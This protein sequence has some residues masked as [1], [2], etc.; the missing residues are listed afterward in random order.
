MLPPG[1]VL[2]G[3]G[4]DAPVA[5]SNT[6][7]LDSLACSVLGQVQ[8]AADFG[9]RIAHSIGARAHRVRLVWQEQDEITGKW[10]EV[11]SLELVPV[12]ITEGR[13]NLDD[14]APGQVPVGQISL[15][16]VSSIQVDEATLRGYLNGEQWTTVP[17]REFFYEVQQ[18]PRCPTDPEPER[19]RYVLAAVPEYKADDLEWRVRLV[20]QFGRRERDGSDA[21][22]PGEFYPPIDGATLMS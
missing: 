9:R 10:S 12:R 22:V 21:T 2:G 13:E 1:C 8:A 17:T 3:P 5:L 20:A 4:P 18:L 19:Y 6:Q 14:L 11:K 7:P 16:E 15:R